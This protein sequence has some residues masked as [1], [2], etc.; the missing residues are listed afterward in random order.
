MENSLGRHGLLPAAFPPPGRAK[1]V[2]AHKTVDV[3]EAMAHQVLRGQ[4]PAAETGTTVVAEIVTNDEARGALGAHRLHGIEY[5]EP[6]GH[7]DRWWRSGGRD[8]FIARLEQ[9][10]DVAVGISPHAP[11]SLDGTVITDLL[12]IA[13]E[14]NMR[15]HSHV[16]ESAKEADRYGHGVGSV[17]SIEGDLRDE[18]ELIR[19]GGSGFTTAE[20]ADSIG[21]LN[22]KS[23]LAHAI[24]RNRE[25]RDLLLHR[26][27]QV[28]L[29]PRSN[30]VIGLDAPPP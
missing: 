29:C 14:R 18:F 17:L 12:G 16:A 28:A 2:G 27:T 19:R 20:Y 26:H 21:L 3:R 11:Y 7:F 30:A 23:H 8:E 13:A 22:R 1:V 4:D 25:E 24:Y 15:V 5:L 9:P 10:S 6:I